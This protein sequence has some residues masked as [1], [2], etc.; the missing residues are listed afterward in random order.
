M[1]SHT[2]SIFIVYLF[3]ASSD[4]PSIQHT[5]QLIQNLPYKT[6]CVDI[7]TA[8]TLSAYINISKHHDSKVANRNREAGELYYILARSDTALW[9]AVLMQARS[10]RKGCGAQNQ[11]PLLPHPHWLL[12]STQWKFNS[13]E[14]RLFN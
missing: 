3:T 12:L 8:L 4:L 1:F 2:N 10:C 11:F 14:P 9:R 5:N 13:P 7:P 6:R